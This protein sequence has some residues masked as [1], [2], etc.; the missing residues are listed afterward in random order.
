MAAYFPIKFILEIYLD[1]YIKSAIIIALLFAS[2]MFYIVI[3][4]IYVNLYKASMNQKKYLIEVIIIIIISFIFNSVLFLLY[5]I[6]ESFALGTLF[7]A[8]V[9]YIICQ[10]DFKRLR[11]RKKNKELIYQGIELV[12]FLTCAILFDSISG[13]ICYTFIT[14]ILTLVLMKESFKNLIYFLARLIKNMSKKI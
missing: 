12:L 5:R 7:S 1:K 14:L 10:I 6:K 8:I 9:W 13:F 11:I 2:Q 3:K 4:S